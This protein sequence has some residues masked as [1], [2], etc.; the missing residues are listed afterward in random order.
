MVT[1]TTISS[2]WANNT[3]SDIANNGLSNCIT[4]DGQ[5]TV[6]A[7]IPFNNNRLTGVGNGVN[8]ADAATLA[9][10]QSGSAITLTGLSGTGDAIVAN[11]APAITSYSTGQTFVYVPTATN[12]IF[13]P[14]INISTVGAKTITQSNGSGLWSGALVVGTPYELLYDGTN[15]RVQ[16]GTLGALIGASSPY[17]LRNRIIDGN[18]FFWDTG[19]SFSFTNSGGY[20]ADMWTCNSGSGTGA[21]T[22]TKGTFSPGAEPA[23]MVTPALNYLSFAQTVGASSGNPFIVHKIESVSTMEGRSATLSLWLWT[24]S[25]TVN[26]TSLNATQNFGSG[27]STS[28]VTNFSV[29]WTVTTTPQKFS[30]RFDVPSISGK[31]VGAGDYL[32]I[33]LAFPG[34][35]TFSINTAQWQFEDCPA[36]APAA[37]L[38]TPFE[39][40]PIPLEQQL[41]SRYL[42]GIPNASGVAFASGTVTSTTAAFASYPIYPMRATPAITTV[43]ASGSPALRLTGGFTP[44]GNATL[45]MGTGQQLLISQVLTGGTAWQS[46]F[47]VCTGGSQNIVLDARL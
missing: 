42:Q 4:K 45:S 35:S 24:A 36:G 39:I 31:T 47:A 30:V 40:R 13:N 33:V 28:V 46:C 29:N 44:T 21:C 1:G 25:G 12:T 37:G 34:V 38:P 10:I 19:N 16:S 3:L 17:A 18:F 41:L 2:T 14:T 7:N 15:F 26:V 23:G 27:G 8:A 20:T 43:T 11:S 5:Q 6:T 32:G 9:Q 22:I